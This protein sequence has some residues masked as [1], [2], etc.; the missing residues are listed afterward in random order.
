MP[1]DVLAW[2]PAIRLVAFALGLGLIAL[3]EHRAPRRPPSVG[4]GARWPGNLGLVL[5]DTLLVRL[6]VPVTTVG[7]AALADRRSWGLLG[8]AGRAVGGLPVWLEPAL[9]VVL[10]DLAIYLQH[11]MFHA[12]P[13]LWRVHRTHHADLDLDVTTGVRFHPIEILLSLGVRLGFVVAIG[14]SPVGVLLFELLLNLSS[15]WSHGNLRLPD[16]LD[17]GLRRVVVTPDMHRVHH[18]VLAP[19]RNANFGFTLAWWDHLCG[20]YRAQPRDGHQAMAIGT[21]EFRDP[22]WLRLDRLLVQPFVGPALRRGAPIRPDQ[23]AS[24]RPRW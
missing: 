1:V 9:V 7:A 17:R 23:A 20:T 4:R 16:A 13:I 19:E 12:V 2:E 21:P 22:G 10:M 6:A 24:I 5:L 11:V 14:P 15:L 18:S 8:A 3:W